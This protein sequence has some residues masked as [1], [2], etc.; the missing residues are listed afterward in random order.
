MIIICSKCGAE[1]PADNINVNTDLAKCTSCNSIHKVSELNNYKTITNT[2]KPP[3]GTRITI[4]EG[5]LGTTEYILNKKGFTGS[6]IFTLFF[7]A[8]WLSFVSVWTF[9]AASGSIFFT[10]FSLPF[11]WVGI[12][13]LLGVLS[14]ALEVQSI[15]LSDYSLILTKKKL[16]K[17]EKKEFAYHEIVSIQIEIMKLDIKNSFKYIGNARQN[18]YYDS[19]R[20]Q[21]KNFVELPCI[22]TESEKENIFETADLQDQEWIIAVL[23]KSLINK[24]K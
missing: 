7:S 22:T 2:S 11:W 18:R 4:S 17:T 8:F 20:S 5:I 9:L 1:I 6:V 14:S 12:S 24:K 13:M 16:F 19:N 23:N 15:R 3:I 21:R 10:L